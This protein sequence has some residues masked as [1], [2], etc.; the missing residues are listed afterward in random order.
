MELQSIY[1]SFSFIHAWSEDL[2][3]LILKNRDELIK[4][5]YGLPG[6]ENK[7]AQT[8]KLVKRMVENLSLYIEAT[9]KLNSV[10]S[11]Y[12]LPN[13]TTIVL[14]CEKLLRNFFVNFVHP[15][16]INNNERNLFSIECIDT[17]SEMYGWFKELIQLI[18]ETWN[19]TTVEDHDNFFEISRLNA[20]ML[21][22]QA[23]TNN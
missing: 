7:H 10:Y 18:F 4:Q 23:P 5:C 9:K 13:A 16:E 11:L 19:N 15:H 6:Y 22:S 8:Y 12:T 14:K 21:L 2:N 17:C 20:S 3:K 1:V